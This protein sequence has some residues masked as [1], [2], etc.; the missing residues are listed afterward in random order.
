MNPVS[1][2]SP[3]LRDKRLL[4][5]F[6]K[7]DEVRENRR[8]AG[9]WLVSSSQYPN[10]RY[11]VNYNPAANQFSCGCEWWQ[12]RGQPCRHLVR[13]AWEVHEAR[14]E[15]RVTQRKAQAQNG[16]GGQHGQALPSLQAALA[17]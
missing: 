15:A 5:S 3:E 4:D 7:G 16:R 17:T 12:Y 1:A 8:H 13:V 6:K 14:R 9:E 10:V 11:R 2:L